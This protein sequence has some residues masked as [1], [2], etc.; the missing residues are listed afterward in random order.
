MAGEK[1]QV[2]AAN[3]VAAEDGVNVAIKPAQF[4]AA[5]VG[6]QNA[7][8]KF[9][10]YTNDSALRSGLTATSPL[11]NSRR[12][13]TGSSPNSRNWAEVIFV[14]LMMDMVGLVGQYS[15]YGMVS[16][17]NAMFRGRLW[18]LGITWLGM[19]ALAYGGAATRPAAEEILP[20]GIV[21]KGPLLLHLPGIAGP[22]WCD[23][24]M[25][26]GLRDGGVDVHCVIY[27][28]TDHDR[29]INALQA[30]QR[31]HREAKKIADMIAAHAAADPDSPID[32]T[33]H[34]GG[35]AGGV[36]VGATA[37][38]R[39]GAD[40]AVARAGI[41]PGYDLS[42]ALRHVEGK[43]FVF[44]STLDVVVLYTGTRLF[45][46]MDGCARPPRVLP[47]SF[48]RRAPI[49][50]FIRSWFN[51][52]IDTTGRDTATS[53]IMAPCRGRSPRRS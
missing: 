48:N 15:K 5:D 51:S 16:K 19:A 44:N 46:T 49:H 14:V 43:A 36:G 6:N 26:D 53:A 42:A 9:S 28:W 8:P 37:G 34:S 32:L 45:G 23:H 17:I 4:F 18:I 10:P 40:G 25:I 20:E 38:R 3:V 35:C 31:N 39:E 22:R 52:N 1:D 12:T 29:G 2:R 33:A 24:Q 13:P 30:Y 11:T 41:S 50:S 47:G 21:T 27:D 7:R